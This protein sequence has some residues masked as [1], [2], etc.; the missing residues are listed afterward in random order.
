[1]YQDPTVS[2]PAPYAPPPPAPTFHGSPNPG[3]GAPGYA[4][5][6]PAPLGRPGTITAAAIMWIIYGGLSLLGNLLSLAGGRVGGSTLM[7]FGIATLFF[8]GGIQLLSGKAR[9]VLGL[10]ITSI[11][12]GGLVLLLCVVAGSVIHELHAAAGLLV[13]IGL[14]FGGYLIVAGILGCSGNAKYK[15]W[16]YHTGRV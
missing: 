14:V 15:Q 1:M 3:Y 10:A 6:Q 9:S 4:P 13:V 5:A 12:L 2:P 8:A 11:V 7:G 16:R